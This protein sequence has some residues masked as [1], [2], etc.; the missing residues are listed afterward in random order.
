MPGTSVTADAVSDIVP[1]PIR[2]KRGRNGTNARRKPTDTELGWTFT[3]SPPQGPI[4][5]EQSGVSAPIDA[6]SSALDCFSIFV[7]ETMVKLFKSE[8]NRYAA[9]ITD[10]LRRTNK[11]K[12]NSLWSLWRPVKLCEIYAFLAVVIHMCLVKKPKL[13]DY[14]SKRTILSTPF[15]SSIMSRNRFKAILS[16]FHLNDNRTY[17]PRGQPNHDPLHKIRPFFDNLIQTFCSSYMPDSKL[18]VDE[19]MCG[20]R[21][22]I[23]FKVYMKNKPEKYG[24]KLFIVCDA[25][26]GYI[27]KMEVY[28]GK[29]TE[30]MGIIPLLTRLLDNYLY[31]GHTIYMDRYY[32]SP[33]V[34]DFLWER[35]T[36]AVGTCM[37]NRKELPQNNIVQ[38]KIQK[39]EIIFMRRNH[40]LCLKW[41]D[42]RDVLFLSTC[43]KA[44]SSDVMV[45]TKEGPK[46][47]SKPDAI[48]DYNIHKT[49]VDRS[50]QMIAYYPFG[51]K[52]LK[53]WKKLFFHMFLMAITNAF[54]LYRETRDVQMR[55]NCHLDQF[56]IELG[57]ALV[58]KSGTEVNQQPISP[59]GCNRLLGRHFVEK[60]PPTGKKARPT[61]TCKVCAD[62][63]KAEDGQIIR[64]ET[65]WW[66]PMCSVALCMPECF[67]KFHT[68]AHYE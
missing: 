35:N 13:S 43:H 27:L 16:N 66:C 7:P 20:F 50:D 40:L 54:V 15:P 10:K 19:G 22:R 4:F 29:G 65:C 6:T 18:T 52:Q 26:S 28:S 2:R 51:R 38:K 41:K 62:K 64:K 17:I 48:L 55:K 33:A 9:S 11:L 63:G 36:K 5:E 60:I 32:S 31:K 45:R 53:W 25:S 67:K 24:I 39:G 61:R 49:G 47:K 23:Q 8:T 21:G 59:T 46:I 56:M 14:W 34:F 1:T 30:D 58:E 3:D 68:Q 12:P 42:T 44:T 57:D 37:T